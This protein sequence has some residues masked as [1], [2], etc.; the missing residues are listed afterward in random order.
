MKNVI[1]SLFVAVVAAVALSSCT[2]LD[3]SIQTVPVAAVEIEPLKRSEYVLMDE[4]EGFGTSSKFLS[5]N[6]AAIASGD[7]SATTTGIAKSKARYDALSKLE[8]ADALVAPKMEVEVFRLGFLYE[9]ATVKI[10]A[11]AI[12]I[13]TSSES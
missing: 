4:V 5:I 1:K 13:K 8:G 7:E 12:R 11:K 2:T 3:R 10:R 6:I 9:K